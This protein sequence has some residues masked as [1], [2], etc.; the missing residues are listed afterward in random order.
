VPQGCRQRLWGIMV[1]KTPP[2]ALQGLLAH[3]TTK[4]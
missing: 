2:D 3:N 1:P 4:Q